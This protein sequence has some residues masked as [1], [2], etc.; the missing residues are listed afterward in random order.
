MPQSSM[1]RN[2]LGK[3]QY[4]DGKGRGD[5]MLTVAARLN[6]ELADRFQA[7]QEQY[8]EKSKTDIVEEALEQFFNDESRL[9]SLPVLRC[10]PIVQQVE[11]AFGERVVQEAL[12][13]AIQMK[14]EAIVREK[15][16]PNPNLKHIQLLKQEIQRLEDL[17][18]SN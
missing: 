9:P 11:S 1:A 3:N 5:K 2:K 17:L 4:A 18:H 14:E 12:V 6:V 13:L 7:Y 8:P 10:E 16:L 15:K